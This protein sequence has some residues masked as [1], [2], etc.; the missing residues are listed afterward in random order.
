MTKSI[1]D[2]KKSKSHSVID[3]VVKIRKVLLNLG[4]EEIINP[5]IVNEKDVYKQYGPEAP[6]ILDRSFYL[7]GLPRPELGISKEIA[8]K[9]KKIVNNID[10][11]KL[12][13]VFREYKEGK[14]EADNLV[15]ELVKRL[16]IKTEQAIAI[17]TLFPW[18]KKLK[19][20]SI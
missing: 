19:P 15:E 14:I 17:L 11:K 6:L 20:I 3:L 10:I 12:Q 9:I 1:L 16:K 5:S 2:N 8:I 13:K 18:L 7:A 4:F